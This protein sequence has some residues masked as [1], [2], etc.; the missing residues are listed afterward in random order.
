MRSV[1]SPT[2]RPGASSPN[3]RRAT[4][5]RR[6]RSP[7]AFPSGLNGRRCSRSIRLGNK[8]TR[9]SLSFVNARGTAP[10]AIELADGTSIKPAS[11]QEGALR[12]AIGPYSGRLLRQNSRI[13]I[14]PCGDCQYDQ[15]KRSALPHAMKRALVALTILSFATLSAPSGHSAGWGPDV[16]H[17]TLA[18]GL[19][20][21]VIPD[22]RTPVV[23]HM[24]LVPGRRRR[25][26]P[27]QIRPRPF[28]RTFVV[29]GH[30]E[31]SAGVVLADRGDHRRFGECLH[32]LRLHRLFPAHHARPAQA[33]DGVRVRPHDRTGAH[34]RRG[35]TGIEGRSGRAQFA[36]RE[37][38]QCA[39]GRTDGCRFVSEP[40]LWPAGDRLAQ[41]DRNARRAT[42]RSR[43]IGASTRRTTP[44]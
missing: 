3:H 6:R 19:E 18:N 38:R 20:V 43:S 7:T 41:R 2:N 12:V 34:R 31:E 17:F 24:V 16:T 27:R 11:T 30:Q 26:D 33:D 21:V 13:A 37:Q 15:S 44:S 9:H 36:R 4:R 29:Q 42:M 1:P 22:R 23:T 39:A 10:R 25:R 8:P 35:E 40:P 28:P 32:L 14:C 5:R